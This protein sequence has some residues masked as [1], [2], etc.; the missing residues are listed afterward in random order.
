MDNIENIKTFT[1]K[2]VMYFIIPGT[3]ILAGIFFEFRQVQAELKVLKNGIER[4]DDRH[5]R[6]HSRLSDQ[7][8]ELKKPNSDKKK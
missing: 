5:D 6:K 8:D 3:F 4:V 1:N 7:V 2:Q